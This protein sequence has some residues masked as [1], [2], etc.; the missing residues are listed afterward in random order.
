MLLSQKHLPSPVECV[1][2]PNTE[3]IAK[4]ICALL[5]AQGG[6]V[7]I[8]VDNKYN[9][10]GIEDWEIEK[11]IQNEITNNIFPMPLVYV[12][13]ES[14]KSKIV[15][16]ITVIK[17][18]LPPYSYKNKYYINKGNVVFKVNG[19]TVE[20]SNGKVIYAKVTGGIASIE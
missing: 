19:K 6:W 12:Q 4:S 16:L 20:D 8:G 2:T 10:V 5:N 7:I 18:S 17:G 9:C 14:Y 3:K 11:E 15:I 13:R 1:S